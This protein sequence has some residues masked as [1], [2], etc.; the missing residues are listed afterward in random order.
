MQDNR[1]RW[2]C[3]DDICL[4]KGVVAENPF[5]DAEKWKLV[6]QSVELATQKSYSVRACRDHLNH[7]LKKF[8][9]EDRANLRKSGTEEEYSTKEQLLQ[10]VKDLKLEF[11]E[12]RKR[13]EKKKTS[14]KGSREAA[15]VARYQ[16]AYS[17]QCSENVDLVVD[18]ELD[19]S[20]VLETTLT[21]ELQSSDCASPVRVPPS[22]ADENLKN[23]QPK[24]VIID[25][26][27]C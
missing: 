24:Q 27:I 10:H 21:E 25:K 7:L 14:E 26:K 3:F 15:V 12:E 18:E 17:I 23:N 13:Q 9:T 11:A 5:N 4:L 1:N 6:Q 22:T 2:S 8:I 19:A 16:A 20:S